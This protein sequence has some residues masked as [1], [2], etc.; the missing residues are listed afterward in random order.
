MAFG[1]Y[2]S[3]TS[4]PARICKVIEEGATGKVGA[5]STSGALGLSGILQHRVNESCEGVKRPNFRR[6]VISARSWSGRTSV[7]N[8][9]TVS[10]LPLYF[11]SGEKNLPM[12][13]RMQW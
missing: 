3:C 9:L 13:K 8:T 10:T 5:I 6:F 11:R 7:E 4:L 2:N 12:P 1:S